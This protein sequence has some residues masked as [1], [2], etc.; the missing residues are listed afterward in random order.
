MCVCV[1]ECVNTDK[2][3]WLKS[4]YQKYSGTIQAYRGKDAPHTAQSINNQST[5]NGSFTYCIAPPGGEL[6][7]GY[8]SHPRHSIPTSNPL[9]IDPPLISPSTPS[10][11]LPFRSVRVTSLRVLWCDTWFMTQPIPVLRAVLPANKQNTDLQCCM[12]RHTCLL[13]LFTYRSV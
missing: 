7:H 10:A 3:W 4:V 9:T 6:Q 11:S 1:T 8:F 13:L 2:D 12:W 5:V